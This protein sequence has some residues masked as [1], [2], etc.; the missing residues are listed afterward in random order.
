VIHATIVALKALRSVEQVAKTRGKNI[1]DF[2]GVRTS[3]DMRG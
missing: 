2:R 3:N 1:S